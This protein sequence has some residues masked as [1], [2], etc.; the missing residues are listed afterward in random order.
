MEININ[1][2]Y[3]AE[4]TRVITALYRVIDPELMINIMDMGLVY[5]VDFSKDNTILITMTLSTPHCPLEEAITSGIRNS[6]DIDF[7][8]IPVRVNIVWEPAWNY[9]MLTAEG[10]EQL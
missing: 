9:S 6:M 10:R 3:Y 2:P 7:P 8:S 4:K 5:N 1:D